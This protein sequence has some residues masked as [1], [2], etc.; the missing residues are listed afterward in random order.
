MTREEL[1]AKTQDLEKEIEIYENIIS[2]IE[3]QKYA[4]Q[5]QLRDVEKQI[6]DIDRLAK[7]KEFVKHVF[8]VTADNSI[9]CALDKNTHTTTLLDSFYASDTAEFLVLKNV[10]RFAKTIDRSVITKH[11][12][13][14]LVITCTSEDI[15]FEKSDLTMTDLKSCIG[16]F[17]LSAP[18]EKETE[19]YRLYELFKSLYQIVQ[20][21]DLKAGYIPFYIPCYLGGQNSRNRQGYGYGYGGRGTYYGEVDT[22]FIIGVQLS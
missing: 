2:K 7:A 13:V 5:D 21:G 10:F 22:Y 8:D 19:D 6:R 16:K 17:I 20:R 12:N 11:W 15:F 3:E 14:S 18:A 9:T 1:V 4:I